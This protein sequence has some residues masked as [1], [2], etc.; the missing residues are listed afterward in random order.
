MPDQLD[1]EKGTV[2]R[3]VE[4]LADCPLDPARASA[5]CRPPGGRGAPM[6]VN[7]PP[8]FIAS[9]VLSIADAGNLSGGGFV[10]AEGAATAAASIRAVRRRG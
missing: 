9:A 6:I 2:G 1:G 3:S 7:T 8:D 5:H 10:G 4:Q